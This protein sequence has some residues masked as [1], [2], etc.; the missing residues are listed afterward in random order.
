MGRWP[1]LGAAWQQVIWQQEFPQE[2]SQKP[3]R[4]G[5]QFTQKAA[6][7]PME[8]Q[9]GAASTSSPPRLLTQGL[10]TLKGLGL[11]LRDSHPRHKHPQLLIINHLKRMTLSASGSL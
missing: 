3:P 9:G 6:A 11:W 4:L 7:T 10:L 1:V 8:T 5:K 2:F